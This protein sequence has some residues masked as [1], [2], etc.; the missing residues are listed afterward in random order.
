MCIKG[1]LHFTLAT[2]V[3]NKILLKL[4]MFNADDSFKMYQS[5]CQLFYSILHQF[6]LMKIY[7]TVEL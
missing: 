4:E 1:N 5:L 3:K 6:A 7:D 2:N